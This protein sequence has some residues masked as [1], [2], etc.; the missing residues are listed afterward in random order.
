[1]TIRGGPTWRYAAPLVNQF[2]PP[3]N[4]LRISL[5]TAATYAP[6]HCRRRAVVYVVLNAAT[7][8]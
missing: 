7:G 5:P 2:R 1:M 8:A 3:I 4:Y 6:L